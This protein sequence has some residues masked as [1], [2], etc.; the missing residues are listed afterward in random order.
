MNNV[1]VF[2]RTALFT[3]G[4]DS[5][6]VPHGTMVLRGA[7]DFEGK[8]SVLVLEASEYMDHR[9]KALDGSAAKL[10]IPMSKVDHILHHTA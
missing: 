4:G 1:T 6:H 10:S 8:G 3:L 2:L 7:S 9:G 5:P